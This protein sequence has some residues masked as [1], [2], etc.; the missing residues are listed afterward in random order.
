MAANCST[1][2]KMEKSCIDC[3]KAQILG[4]FRFKKGKF[5][6]WEVFFPSVRVTNIKR[7]LLTLKCQK[8]IFWK[9]ERRLTTFWEFGESSAK[10]RPIMGVGVDMWASNCYATLVIGGQ[11]VAS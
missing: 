3:E 10:S 8:T 6:A 11:R 7:K 5:F 2:K 4:T 1:K 9:F